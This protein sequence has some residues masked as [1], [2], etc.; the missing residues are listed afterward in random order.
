MNTP[1]SFRNTLAAAATVLSAACATHGTYSDA[2]RGPTKP[3]PA[4]PV[5]PGQ[6]VPGALNPNC[7]YPVKLETVASNPFNG[8][9]GTAAAINQLGLPM[10]SKFMS[11]PYVQKAADGQQVFGYSQD[12]RDE[13]QPGV[14]GGDVFISAQ[15]YNNPSTTPIETVVHSIKGQMADRAHFHDLFFNGPHSD[16]NM[17]GVVKEAAAYAGMG[18]SPEQIVAQ[19]KVTH[20]TTMQHTDRVGTPGFHDKEIC[21]NGCL[22][23]Q[24]I[25]LDPECK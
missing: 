21:Q 22:N 13:E 8:V 11:V 1:S 24:V 25:S 3:S 4:Q 17:H 14:P 15:L 20:P 10:G 5:N 7:E 18:M 12:L 16:D 9:H 19:L 2:E 6:Q 23:M